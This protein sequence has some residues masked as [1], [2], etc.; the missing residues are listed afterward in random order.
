MVRL[1]RVDVTKCYDFWKSE[2]KAHVVNDPESGF[3]LDGY[4]GEYAYVASEW[5]GELQSPI[6][7]LEKHH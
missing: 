5:S 3:R 6:V 2:V 7:L 4:P 1:R